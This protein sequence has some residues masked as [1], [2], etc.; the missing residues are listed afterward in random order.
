MTNKAIDA[1]SNTEV[2]GRVE[3]LVMRDYVMD[4]DLPGRE[5]EKPSGLANGSLIMPEGCMINDGEL[6]KFG[7]NDIYVHCIMTGT[8]AY[9]GIYKSDDPNHI[10]THLRKANGCVLDA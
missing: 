5:I 6:V 1:E 7:E 9:Y 10:Y 8:S 3:P 2:G 4:V